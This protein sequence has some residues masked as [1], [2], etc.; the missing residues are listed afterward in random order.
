MLDNWLYNK[1]SVSGVAGSQLEHPTNSDWHGFAEEPASMHARP[2]RFAKLV[3]Q[4]TTGKFCNPSFMLEIICIP[5]WFSF[6]ISFFTCKINVTTGHWNTVFFSDSRPEAPL[7]RTV[8]CS[9]SRSLKWRQPRHSR[10]VLDDLAFRAG[11]I[12]II[13]SGFFSHLDV[14]KNF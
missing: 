1:I 10:Q 14:V 4:F 12:F 9:Q 11:S 5:F 3:R 7:V 6:K 13:R 2:W 8:S